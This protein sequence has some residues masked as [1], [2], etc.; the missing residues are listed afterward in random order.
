MPRLTGL[1]CVEAATISPELKP[2][3]RLGAP[4]ILFF[5]PTEEARESVLSLQATLA[6]VADA[7]ELATAERT[8]LVLLGCFSMTLDGR[9]E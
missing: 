5:R 2:L 9:D 1:S 3:W 6:A 8:D 7:D 4:L